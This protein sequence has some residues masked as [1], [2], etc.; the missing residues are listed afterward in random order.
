M[1]MPVVTG[2]K[3]ES[4]RF[5]GAVRTYSCEA[6]M[7]DNRALQAAGLRLPMPVLGVGGGRAEARGRGGEPEAALREVA[8]NVTGA[9]IADC[10]HFIPEEKPRELAALL[11]AHFARG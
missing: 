2:Q 7:Q 4:E 6:M 3:T 8:A 11:R 1:A 5:A 9:V 10:G